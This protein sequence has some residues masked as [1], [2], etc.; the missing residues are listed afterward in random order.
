MDTLLEVFEEAVEVTG[1]SLGSDR[2]K[3]SKRHRVSGSQ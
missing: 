3:L 2:K 1:K